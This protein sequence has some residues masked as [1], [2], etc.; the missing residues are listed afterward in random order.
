M[1]DRLRFG[2]VGWE[3]FGVFGL[4]EMDLE[5]KR[6][7][8]GGDTVRF[9]CVSM[10]RAEKSVLTRIVIQLK[11]SGKCENCKV[12]GWQ[13]FQYENQWPDQTYIFSGDGTRE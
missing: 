5:R 9:S 8:R 1:V 12:K 3:L 2:V 4:L 13:Q 11:E 7:N 10:Q 6:G